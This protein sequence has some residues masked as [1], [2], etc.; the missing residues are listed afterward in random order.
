MS[1]RARAVVLMK[2]LREN[3]WLLMANN[4]VRRAHLNGLKH[5]QFRMAPGQCGLLPVGEC[6]QPKV[7]ELEARDNDFMR[8]VHACNLLP[9]HGLNKLAA[10]S[11]EMCERPSDRETVK[12]NRTRFKDDQ[13]SLCPKTETTAA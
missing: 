6:L 4:F 8:K 11:R 10:D 2:S 9:G 13:A 5:R 1:G 7:P 3:E 12:I